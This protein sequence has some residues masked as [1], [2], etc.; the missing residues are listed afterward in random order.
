MEIVLASNNKG[1]IKEIKEIFNDYKIHSLNDKNIDIDV[2]EDQD[3]FE[4]NA[5]KKAKEIYDIV[6]MPVIADDSGFCISSLD[7]F[8]GVHSNRYLGPNK[9]DEDRNIDLINRT[10]NLED[11]SA[12]LITVIVYY[13]GTT[14]L[15][16]VGKI[17]GVVSRSIRGTNGFA[18]D[19]ILELPNGKTIAELPIEE[20]NEISSRSLALKSIKSQLGVKNE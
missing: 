14:K 7:D 1:K 18:Y 19:F 16:G 13:D 2:I 10:E 15:V 6:K 3:T 12:Y 11:K 17:E 4:G 20:K 5:F 9:T 8:P